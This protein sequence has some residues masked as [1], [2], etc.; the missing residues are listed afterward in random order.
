MNYGFS[1]TNALAQWHPETVLFLLL[2]AVLY[3]VATR[4]GPVPT[5]GLRSGPTA[6]LRGPAAFFLA[7]ALVY[8]ALGTPLNSVA[9]NRLFSAHMAQSLLLTMAVP[10]LLLK[11]IP[12]W[13]WD[14]ALQ[15]RGLRETLSV[16]VRPDIALVLFNVLFSAALFPGALD[17]SLRLDWLHVL[18]QLAQFLAALFLWWPV[19]SPSERLP[20]LT[21]GWRMLYLFFCGDLMMPASVYIPIA[22]HPLYGI[23]AQSPRLFG[24]SALADQQFGGVLMFLAMS[25]AYGA[26]FFAAY[27]QQE[28]GLAWYD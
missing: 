6:R 16:L 8:I 9:N 21:P 22:R 1:T 18:L 15:V 28:E 20:R 2:A 24:I 23:Y 13:M 27:A 3:T 4:P 7:L 11:G 25:I 19:L 12:A 10:P 17:A 14:A 26:A 5:A